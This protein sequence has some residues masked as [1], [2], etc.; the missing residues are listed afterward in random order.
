M[1][2]LLQIKKS[3]KHLAVTIISTLILTFILSLL[4]FLIFKSD[5]SKIDKQKINIGIVGD[6]KDSYLGVGLGILETSDS[7][8]FS[9]SF[10]ALS[11]KEAIEK[12]QKEEITAFLDMPK[13]FITALSEGRHVPLSLVTMKADNSLVVEIMKEISE[14]ISVTIVNSEYSVYAMQEYL[15]DHKLDN[16]LSESTDKL[17]LL[18]LNQVFKRNN[19]YQIDYYGI[20]K[21]DSIFV[22]YL[23]AIIILFLL[24]WGSNGGT[25]L[26]K[27]DFSIYKLLNLYK[28]K[29]NLQVLSEFVAYVFMIVLNLIF[30]FILFS[31]AVLYFEIDTISL[32][33]NIDLVQLFLLSFP[34][35]ILISSLHFLIFEFNADILT[36]IMSSIIIS[37]LM[38]YISGVFYPTS[39][40]P[41]TIAMLGNNSP[42]GVSFRYLRLVLK[43][44]Y[45]LKLLI[46]ILLYTIL[47]LG[48]SIFL[49]K[50]R[51]KS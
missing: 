4:V 38:A 10:L 15:L 1:Y 34:V 37:I 28:V 39:F 30:I 45:S 43:D 21:S 32:G 26:Y 46:Y 18:L 36:S 48:I 25:L 23:S 35:I 40:F 7:S 20:Y 9:I 14:V 11:K 47:F 3:L 19:F 41:K 16:K 22:Y 12:L 8:R 2:I 17:N 42:V 27:K 31:I 33:I 49:R 44:E 5:S 13:D 29:A 51:L 6:V 50:R 24:L